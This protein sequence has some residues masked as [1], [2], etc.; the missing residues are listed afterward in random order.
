VNTTRRS[1]SRLRWDFSLAHL[2]ISFE[3]DMS[4]QT[5]TE[6]SI[7]KCIA[8]NQQTDDQILR[9]PRPGVAN[10]DKI[11]K[12]ITRCVPG[13]C[14]ICQ[15]QYTDGDSIV[16]SCNPKCVHCYHYDCIA[17]WMAPW[18]P[19]NRLCPCCRELFM[20]ETTTT[21]ITKSEDGIGWNALY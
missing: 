8:C 9:I 2:F 1:T 11:A 15:N 19:R 17:S 6:E 5:V 21:I 3:M 12:R 13:E 20:G 16:W 10:D 7:E 18:E 4:C 14:A